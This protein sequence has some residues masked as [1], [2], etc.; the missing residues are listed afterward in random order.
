L[1]TSVVKRVEPVVEAYCRKV[2]VGTERPFGTFWNRLSKRFGIAGEAVGTAIDRRSRGEPVDIYDLKNNSLDLS[3]AVASQYSGVLYRQYLSWFVREKFPSPSAILDVGCES[4]VLTCFYAQTY[5][6]A[7][8]IGIDRSARAVQC[9][10]ELASRLKLTNVS[11]LH[12]DFLRYVGRTLERFSLITAS[13]VFK[14][15]IPFPNFKEP[16]FSEMWIPAGDC[17]DIAS[18][19]C[20]LLVDGGSLISVERCATLR[21]LSWWSKLLSSAV[22]LDWERSHLLSFGVNGERETFPVLF[23]TRS[24]HQERATDEDIIAFRSYAD[25]EKKSE[26]LVFQDASAEAFWLALSPKKFVQGVEASYNDGSGIERLELWTAGPLAL[27]YQYS[28]R[29]FRRLCLRSKTVISE[30]LPTLDEFELTKHGS[31][32]M[33]RYCIPK[34]DTSCSENVTITI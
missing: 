29:G 34:H 28:N 4:G 1:N 6:N 23:G 20:D 13:L 26:Q 30:L 19:L 24:T 7:K 15:A 25:L 11:F 31:A 2:G 9:A 8:V 17:A 18:G 32:T 33:A 5:P 22:P 12:S 27:A 10:T 21:D 14:E 16:S 3:L